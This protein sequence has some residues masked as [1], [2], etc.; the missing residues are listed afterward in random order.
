MS[1][2]S[3]GLRFLACDSL[4]WV[5]RA[6]I[7]AATSVHHAQMRTLI[8]ASTLAA[9]FITGH[10][11]AQTTPAPAAAAGELRIDWEVKNRFRL[12]RAERDFQR[13]VV[14][15]RGDGVLAAENRLADESDG[16]GW[17]RDT[18]ERL[19]T[20]R[21]GTLTETCERDGVRENY[22]TPTDHRIGVVLGGAAPQGARCIWSFDDGQASPQQQPAVACEEEVRL[23]VSYG[24]KTIA[25]ANVMVNDQ[26]QQSISAEIEVQDMLIAGLGDSIAAGEGNPD[27]PIALSDSGF[28]F[29]RFGTGSEYY[30]PGRAGFR[31]ARACG[32]GPGDASAAAEWARNSA[33]WM[34]GPCH[35]S[36]YGYQMRT[37]L[38]LAVE[39]PHRAVTFIP[40]AC[41]GAT[42][43]A[44]LLAAQ[45]AR[46]CA[47]PGQASCSGSVRGQVEALKQALASAQRRQAD[48]AL[49]LLLLTIGANDI[50]FSGLVADV[51]V[52]DSAKRVL[53]KQGGVIVSPDESEKVLETQLPG[54]FAKLR[55]AL[56]PL[57]G[58]DL[59]RI[60]YVSYGHPA[61]AGPG[62]PCPGGRDGFD[63]HPAFNADPARL[64]RVSEFVSRRF[65]PRV[66]AL[67]LCESGVLCGNPASERMTFVDAHQAEFVAHGFCARGPDDPD[68][69]RECF[70]ASGESFRAD[71]ADAPTDP[72][73]CGESA[74]E[75][76][77]YASR[78]RWVR[79]ANDSYFAAMTYPEGVPS[80]MQP[81]DI[82]DATWA[83]LASVYGGAVHP[84]AEGHA[85]MADAA[86]PAARAVL[87]LDQPPAV[88]AEPLPPP[89]VGG[90]PN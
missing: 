2:V 56:K 63:V 45:R 71:P 66:K 85:A 90:G 30:R 29:R 31:G 27:R 36:L 40:L 54:S 34:S 15:S 11:F 42:I 4:A 53:F 16:R 69:D 62:T 65:L 33:R 44:G 60:V 64:A 59:K 24:R 49:D 58:G 88:Q 47:T 48:R 35:R 78:K 50:H 6:H 17:A 13:H 74:S 21:A 8:L 67:A 51:I 9:L 3:R 76:R 32:T 20:D 1:R 39:N 52:D 19:C 83:V 68:F 7:S 22:L 38:T 26:L 10:A 87:G 57:V 25:T 80:T 28:C 23:R 37:A 41:T 79:T 84:T 14:A 86:L 72:M 55:T 75:F 77:P 61:L 82:H 18:V 73:A 12:F 89:T 43:E 46:E 70:S 5:A 81:A